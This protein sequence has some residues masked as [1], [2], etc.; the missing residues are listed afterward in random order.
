MYPTFAY[1]SCQCRSRVTLKCAD[2]V[3]FDSNPLK[4]S[5]MDFE[6][7]F[8]PGGEPVHGAWSCPMNSAILLLVYGVGQ[9]KIDCLVCHGDRSSCDLRL[10][11]FWVDEL[12]QYLSENQACVEVVPPDDSDNS[13]P[14]A[15][16]PAPTQPVEGKQVFA[17]MNLQSLSAS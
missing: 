17:D 13:P 7:S 11:C 9:L 2:I 8:A 15:W 12:G 10:H 6:A 3:Y 16:H 4:V 1:G 5:G 14:V